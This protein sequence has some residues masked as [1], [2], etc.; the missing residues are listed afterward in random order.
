MKV[1]GISGSISSTSR[2]TALVRAVAD[3]AAHRAGAR[4]EVLDLRDV[5]LPFCDGRDPSSYDGD[6]DAILRKV[7]EA[8][9]VVV[10]TPVYQGSLTGVLKNFL[11]LLPSSVWRHKIVGLVVTGGTYQ[12][13][14]VG[15]NQLKPIFSYLRAYVAPGYIYAHNAHFN[16][17]KEVSDPEILERVARLGDELVHLFDKVGLPVAAQA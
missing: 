15:E 9:V 1:L 3:R 10:G 16:A 6:V 8:D 4:C 7:R 12:H 14:L 11:D 17:A 5:Q 2:T 13:F